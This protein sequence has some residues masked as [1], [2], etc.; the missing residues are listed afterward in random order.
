VVRQVW[1]AAILSSILGWIGV[2]VTGS[3]TSADALS[4]R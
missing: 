2:A 4:G 3:D 1:P